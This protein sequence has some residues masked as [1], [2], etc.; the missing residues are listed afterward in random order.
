MLIALSNTENYRKLKPIYSKGASN[1][2]RS[3]DPMVTEYLKPKQ[4]NSF[5]NGIDHTPFYRVYTFYRDGFRNMT[6]GKKLWRIILVKLFVMFVILKLF[7]FPNFLNTSFD[8]DEEKTNY[9]LEQMTRDTD[10]GYLK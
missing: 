10:P 2:K 3:I 8:T 1:E 9:V 6:L 7:F 5:I 4:K